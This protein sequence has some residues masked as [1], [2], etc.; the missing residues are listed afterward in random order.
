MPLMD[1]AIST[2]RPFNYP[3]IQSFGK[4]S[5]SDSFAFANNEAGTVNH[6]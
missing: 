2:S 6:T 1:A 4:S 3:P 5:G